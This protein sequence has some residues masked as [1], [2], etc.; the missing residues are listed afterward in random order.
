[1]APQS[2]DADGNAVASHGGCLTGKFVF[3]PGPKKYSAR[4]M[5]SP[6]HASLPRRHQGSQLIIGLAVI[7]TLRS[8]NAQGSRAQLCGP[9]SKTG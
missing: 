8:T 2:P 7:E 5:L 1:M 9:C 3:R 6:R 4:L